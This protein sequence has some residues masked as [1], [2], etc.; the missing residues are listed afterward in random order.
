M[1][2][3]GEGVVVRFVGVGWVGVA[4]VVLLCCV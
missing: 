3:L 1:G 4:F 2:V